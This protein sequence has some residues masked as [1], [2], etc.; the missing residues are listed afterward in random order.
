MKPEQARKLAQLPGVLSG[1]LEDEQTGAPSR[2]PL[3]SCEEDTGGVSGVLEVVGRH[4]FH[5]WLARQA[6]RLSHLRQGF[7]GKLLKHGLGLPD[8]YHLHA[9]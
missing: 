1:S 9:T 8:I 5:L 3:R 7:L 2:P 4:E 6:N